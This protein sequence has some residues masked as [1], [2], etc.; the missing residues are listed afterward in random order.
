MRKG[1]RGGRKVKW[2]HKSC[3]LLGLNITFSL[4]VCTLHESAHDH[5]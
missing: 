4:H 3:M 2:I 1:G 5:M